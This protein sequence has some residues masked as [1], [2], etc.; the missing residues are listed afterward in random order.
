MNIQ[1]IPPGNHYIKAQQFLSLLWPECPLTTTKNHGI[2]K[3]LLKQFWFTIFKEHT[4][5]YLL[6]CKQ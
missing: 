6:D 1:I 2:I 4:L 3:N 5:D